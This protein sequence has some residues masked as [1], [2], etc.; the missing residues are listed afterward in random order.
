MKTESWYAILAW[1]YNLF[2]FILQNWWFWK[3]HF[4]WG[5]CFSWRPWKSASPCPQGRLH[6]VQENAFKIMLSFLSPATCREAM[7]SL[8]LCPHHGVSPPAEWK[9]VTGMC[10]LTLPKRHF[11][12]MEIQVW[13]WSHSLGLFSS[14]LARSQVWLL[15]SFTWAPLE[16]TEPHR[17]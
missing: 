11:L 2:C 6:L 9:E 7:Q 17:A 4:Y 15:V 1:Q 14:P 13:V 10:F 16:A 5:L 12:P 3:E 8:P